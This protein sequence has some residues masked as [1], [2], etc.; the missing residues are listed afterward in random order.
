[1]IGIAI[2]LFVIVLVFFYVFKKARKL[3]KQDTS[4]ELVQEDAYTNNLVED[5]EVIRTEESKLVS[6]VIELSQKIVDK[7]EE[8][9]T[10]VHSKP[11]KKTAM[12]K[13]AKK[14]TAKKKTTKKV[15]K[16]K[17]EKV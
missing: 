7:L 10:I 11:K 6:E 8:R 15:K 9:D 17:N 13:S 12:K 14:K 2:A 4:L 1:M 5:L 16:P 3:E